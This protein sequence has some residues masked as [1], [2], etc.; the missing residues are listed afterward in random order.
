MSLADILSNSKVSGIALTEKEKMVG[1]YVSGLKSMLMEYDWDWFITLTFKYPVSDRV[2]V[3]TALDRFLNNLSEKAFGK[4]SRKRVV[5]F[6]VIEKGSYDDSLHVHLMI[7]DPSD[8]I[9]N[10]GRRKQFKLRDAVIESWLSSS[11]FSGNP[12]LSSS[13]DEWIKPIHNV[14]STVNYMMKSL[15]F[16][17]MKETDIIPWDQV[18]ID[19]RK[20]SL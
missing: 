11:S 4:R 19:G 7:Q 6:S 1:R 15:G 9:L 16:S 13:G 17:H 12:A 10:D 3:S 18:T 2:I 14:R 8:R 20:P 5:S